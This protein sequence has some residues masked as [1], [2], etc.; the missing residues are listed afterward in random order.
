MEQQQLPSLRR[1]DWTKN[2]FLRWVKRTWSYMQVPFLTR[3]LRGSQPSQLRIRKMARVV[4]VVLQSNSQRGSAGSTISPSWW[5]RC[6]KTTRTAICS[7][8]LQLL[9]E[10][11]NSTFQRYSSM[12]MDWF[13][14]IPIRKLCRVEV[15]LSMV[16][17]TYRLLASGPHFR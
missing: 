4:A 13:N 9:W 15:P 10:N 5:I 6:S 8:N 12:R 14:R 2:S 3:W 17:G 16:A 11:I 7:L 1:S